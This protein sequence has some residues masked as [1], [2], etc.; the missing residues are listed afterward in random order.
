MNIGLSQV[1]P[2]VQSKILHV[3]NT[4][5]GVEC[6]AHEKIHRIFSI[7]LDLLQVKIDNFPQSIQ[8]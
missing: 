4:R 7:V 8:N 6:L 2:H 3:C 5:Q 1:I